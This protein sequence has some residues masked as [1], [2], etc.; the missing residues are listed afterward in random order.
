MEEVEAESDLKRDALAAVVELEDVAPVLC[1]P[2]QRIPQVAI[3]HEVH[4]QDGVPLH[5]TSSHA[6][7]LQLASYNEHHSSTKQQQCNSGT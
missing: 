1:L 5:I 3:V 4:C 7:P 6:V 2:R